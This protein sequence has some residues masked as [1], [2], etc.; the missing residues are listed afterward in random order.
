[1]N[2]KLTSIDTKPEPRTRPEANPT[3]PTTTATPTT[4]AIPH[5][6]QPTPHPKRRI[7]REIDLGHVTG[8]CPSF[9]LSH[10]DPAALQTLRQSIQD[11]LGARTP[12]ELVMA[13]YATADAW[14][15]LRAH[16]LLGSCI[17]TEIQENAEAVDREYEEIDSISRTAL[18][19]FN[20]NT[21]RVIHQF[22]RTAARCHRI[23]RQVFPLRAGNSRG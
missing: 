1:M 16:T 7:R 17:D 13:E 14:L 8:A 11:Q 3:A 20:A 6:T 22:E 23:L 4:A 18:V 21:A 9:L 19:F 2:Q 15:G 5:P 12:A 10:E